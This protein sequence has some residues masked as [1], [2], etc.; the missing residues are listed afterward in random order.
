MSATDSILAADHAA[1][2]G[3]GKRQVWL[4]VATLAAGLFVDVHTDLLGQVAVSVGVWALL[5]YLLSR[6]DRNQRY[7]LMVCLAIATL[8]EMFCSLVWGLYTYRLHNIP[9]FVPPGHVLLLLLALS[10]SRRMRDSGARAILGG[11]AIYS[12]AAV[13][14]GVDTLAAPL[15]VVFAVASLTMPGHR[16]LFAST[17]VLALA[18]EL[19]GTWLGNWTWSPV[20]PGTR[21]MTTNPPGVSGA[22]YCA[23][24]AMVAATAL[25]LVPRW[26]RSAV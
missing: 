12:L 19:Y 2:T 9:M 21:L 1:A 7:A 15:F 26:S 8:G 4:I 22:F 24:D 3:I 6:V 23:L 14:T 11:A 5:L 13:T 20:V 18:L 10:A 25:L 17:F 16:R